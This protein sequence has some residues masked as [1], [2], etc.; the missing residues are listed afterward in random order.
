M[1][2]TNAQSSTMSSQETAIEADLLS[3]QKRRYRQ[4]T[5]EAVVALRN[6]TGENLAAEPEWAVLDSLPHWCLL[7]GDELA[8]LQ[9]TAGAVFLQPVIK[10]NLE[11]E[12]F[13]QLSDLLGNS[14]LQKLMATDYLSGDNAPA[15]GVELK[16]GEQLASYL[17]SCGAAVLL[18]TIDDEAMQQLFRHRLSPASGVLPGDIAEPLFVQAATLLQAE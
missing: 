3:Q 9:R 15:E 11:G 16:S 17:D 18:G 2:M 14:V 5:A 1:T 13:R 10:T 7:K 8:T 4:L 6:E 12:L